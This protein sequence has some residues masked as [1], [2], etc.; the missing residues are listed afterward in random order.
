MRKFLTAAAC[1]ALCISLAACAG[2]P[3]KGG[4]SGQSQQPDAS[5]SSQTETASVSQEIE[6]YIAAAQ[7]EIDSL[8]SSLKSSGME[9]KLT[10]R[11][12]SLVYSYQYSSVGNSDALKTAL[13]EAMKSTEATFKS[14]LTDLKQSVKSAE[15]VI[16]E[17]IDKDGVVITSTEFK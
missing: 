9:L 8:A 16:V 3:A 7:K 10:A 2:G 12:K 15:S 1:I 4:S 14:V 17:Y 13:D 6:A 11:D 5:N